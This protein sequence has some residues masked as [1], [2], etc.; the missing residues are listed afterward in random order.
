MHFLILY[1]LR[2]NGS[3]F[4]AVKTTVE[5]KVHAGALLGLYSENSQN[6]LFPACFWRERPTK[7]QQCLAPRIKETHR[8][9]PHIFLILLDTNESLLKSLV[10]IVKM[11]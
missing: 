8:N 5:E 6:V 11:D 9:R 7:P 10:C 4:R 3:N 1:K 2:G